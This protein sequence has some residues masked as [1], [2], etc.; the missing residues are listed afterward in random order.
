MKWV[1][2]ASHIGPVGQRGG[3]SQT[4]A[5]QGGAKGQVGGRMILHRELHR[6][7]QAVASIGGKDSSAAAVVHFVRAGS[8]VEAL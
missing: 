2:E 4:G 1:E 6:S 7:H 5:R 8:A 3:N